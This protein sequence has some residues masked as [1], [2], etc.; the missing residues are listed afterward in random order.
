MQYLR[1]AG[2]EVSAE[3]GIWRLWEAPQDVPRA[4]TVR[5]V[6]MQLDP[7]DVSTL[8]RIKGNLDDVLE[9]RKEGDKLNRSLTPPRSAR[10]RS[11]SNK[12]ERRGKGSAK[13]DGKG[14]QDAPESGKARLM[15]ARSK[16]GPP[17]G[18]CAGSSNRGPSQVRQGAKRSAGAPA[19]PENIERLASTYWRSYGPKMKR[20]ET[21]NF[22]KTFM[23]YNQ[24][25]HFVLNEFVKGLVFDKEEYAPILS[26]LYNGNLRYGKVT[27][28]NQKWL[29]RAADG[30]PISEDKRVSFDPAPVWTEDRWIFSAVCQ[31]TISV[32]SFSISS[33]P[34]FGLRMG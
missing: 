15:E 31:E 4:S 3:S 26:V 16:A 18:S 19:S 7:E 30:H 29:P 11:K 2:A 10:Q 23:Y 21:G 24:R 25:L 5:M 33:L 14:D 27:P 20:H 13:G 32:K 8:K 6:E 28:Y 9:N 12:G 1:K 17:V 34:S 22:P